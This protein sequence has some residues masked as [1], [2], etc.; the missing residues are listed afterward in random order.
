MRKHKSRAIDR[1]IRLEHEKQKL[2]ARSRADQ[3]KL[4]SVQEALEGM[5]MLSESEE[6][7]V[8]RRSQRGKMTPVRSEQAVTRNARALGQSMPQ[9]IFANNLEVGG[10]K[11]FEGA[12]KVNTLANKEEKV[13]H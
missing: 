2:E 11:V 13:R 7:F 10:G 4:D 9:P 12:P 1:S 3:A 6:E 8:G 5:E